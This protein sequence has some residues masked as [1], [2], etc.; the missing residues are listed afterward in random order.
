[1]STNSCVFIGELNSG[2]AFSS[3]D[4][5]ALLSGFRLKP[6]GSC[7]N[8]I[9]ARMLATDVD[10]VRGGFFRL[11]FGFGRSRSDSSVSEMTVAAVS[12]VSSVS[13]TMAV[14]PGSGVS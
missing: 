1:M 5:T 8:G 13:F 4:E 7:D 11:R 12:C 9:V 6:A 10:S 14:G 2:G 3:S